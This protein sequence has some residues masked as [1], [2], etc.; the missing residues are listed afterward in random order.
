M[1]EKSTQSKTA[2]AAPEAPQTRK[3]ILEFRETAWAAHNDDNEAYHSVLAQFAKV[4]AQRDELLAAAKDLADEVKACAR[5]CMSEAKARRWLEDN[6][7]Y[8][9]GRAAIANAARGSK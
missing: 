8:V 4:I 3:Q 1:T 5:D 9:S 6:E 2:A 7:R